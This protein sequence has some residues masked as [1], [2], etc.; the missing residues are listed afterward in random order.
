MQMQLMED[1]E[2]MIKIMKSGCS[3]KLR[4]ASR[5][6]RVNV[7][8]IVERFQTDPYMAVV[9][10]HTDDQAADMY[11][12][13]FTDPVKWCDL[14]YL[15]N[16]FDTDKLWKSKSLD[17]YVQSVTGMK[18]D[19]SPKVKRDKDGNIKIAPGRSLKQP[20]MGGQGAGKAG[21]K[22]DIRAVGMQDPA[23]T[24]MA[25]RREM[26]VP[27]KD[28]NV[29][30]T[31]NKYDR[32]ILEYCCG[33]SSKMGNATSASNGCKVVRLTKEHDLT[34]KAGLQYALGEV[35]KAERGKL[36]LW[37]SIPCTGGCPFQAVWKA[38]YT[39]TNNWEGPRPCKTIGNCSANYGI[40]LSSLLMQCSRRAA[41]L[42]LNGLRVVHI[43]MMAASYSGS[44]IM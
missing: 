12:K 23:T 35:R 10:T 22:E 16:T 43:G 18:P 1:N 44:S 5:T 15:N 13:R 26:A 20:L 9:P 6:H 27:T 39:R 4:H 30:T 38:V 3:Q 41:M 32:T 36:L 28:I 40:T 24:P 21:G 33:P 34:T 37:S 8:F 2:A 42:P 19:R 7:S 14:L 25:L 11:T 29:P 17:D 31:S